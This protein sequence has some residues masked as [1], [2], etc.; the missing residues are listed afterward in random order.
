MVPK[1]AFIYLSKDANE[2]HGQKTLDFAWFRF[3][4]CKQ[5]ETAL[6]V[7]YVVLMSLLS[8]ANGIVFVEFMSAFAMR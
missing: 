3:C 8:Q 5:T 7:K 6:F 2:K 4:L 1:L